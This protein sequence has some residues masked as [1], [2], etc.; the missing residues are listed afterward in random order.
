MADPRCALL[1]G[2]GRYSDP[3]HPFAAT[4]PAVEDALR[5]GGYRVDVADDVD[6][7]LAALATGPLPDLLAINVGLPRDGADVPARDAAV[8]LRRYLGSRRPL[9]AV[10]VSSTSFTGLDEWE[11]ALGGR[12][13]RGVSMHPDQSLASVRVRPHA[14]TEGIDDFTVDDER[15]SYLR[16]SPDVQ[17]LAAHEHGGIEHP[18]V[19]V[20]EADAQFG[21][22]AYDAL[23]HDA[24][25]Y[26]S[27]EHR[28]LLRRLVRWLRDGARSSVSA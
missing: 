23:G 18:L 5:D 17:V 7:A 11:S 25:S 22:A 1:T 3:W 12:W 27:P 8:G 28:R 26:A 4:T 14:L 16:V 20:R 6:A 19:W 15:Y 21:R 10:H 2:T 24:Q 9:L 13:L